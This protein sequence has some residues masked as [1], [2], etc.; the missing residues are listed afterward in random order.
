MTNTREN[1]MGVMPVNKL[2]LT[3]SLP[4]M[5][6]MLVQAL[7]NIVDSIF[8]AQISENAL[9]AVSLAFPVQNLMI[10]VASGTAVG[11]NAILSRSLGARDREG[12]S[13][14]A[15][16]GILLVFIS[17]ILFAIFGWY[18]SEAFF[19]LQ[20]EIPEII[21]SG[22]IYLKLCTV[23]SIGV[24]GQI[25]FERLLVSTGKTIF[26]M[27]SQMV[28]AVTNIILD[29]ILIFGLFGAPEMGVAGAAVATII[30]QFLGCIIAGIFNVFI[31]KELNF[32]WG[33][34]KFS[35]GMVKKIYAVGIPSI[36][37]MS[38]TSVTVFSLNK[39]LMVFSSTAVAVLGVYYKLQS[40]VFMPIFGLNNGMIPIIAFNYG[41]NNKKRVIKTIKCA[42]VY[43]ISI[44]LAGLIVFQAI[45]D[46][47]LLLFKASADM[48]ELGCVALRTISLSFIFAGFC[49][50]MSSMFQALGKGISSMVL[51]IVRQLVVL[52]PA[53]YL[54][55]LSGN[56]NAVWWGFPIAEFG[57]VITAIILMKRIYNS[58]IK[59]LG[60]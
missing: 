2:L 29:P 58:T 17:Y 52:L 56:V 12:A 35:L 28:G 8:V 41:A 31:N 40:F 27:I 9:T 23:L 50:I 15:R 24:F 14:A 26:S 19:K 54:L 57:C 18:G 3:M 5:V 4:M 46:K 55:S 1:K 22:T 39:I 60:E 30:G 33:N 32:S 36:I 6:S 59:N 16:H 48:I 37:M 42:V 25:I 45:P 34:F 43:A 13:S 51:S 53:A 11:V 49:I 21:E 38:I 7:Y 20:T 44:M 10:S 47:L